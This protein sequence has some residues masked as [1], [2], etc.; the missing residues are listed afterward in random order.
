MKIEK[1][2]SHNY[3]AEIKNIIAIARRK[4]YS[5]VN[6]AMVE[7]YWLIGKRIVEE[8]QQGATRAEYGKEIIKNLSQELT[9]EF[10][11]GF[12]ERS[13]WQYRQFY[14]MFRHIE[15]LRTPFA[16]LGNDDKTANSANSV[17]GIAT[18]N[19]QLLGWSHIQRIMRISNPKAREW[20]LTDE[21]PVTEIEKQ[22]LMLKMH[23]KEE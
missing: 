4:A 20:Y 23:I 6:A 15:I 13:V 21:E 5:A 18:T 2:N 9:K 10:G 8:E 3:I 7:A 1:T 17:R 16:E 12:S 11:K 22:K 14:Q 19:F